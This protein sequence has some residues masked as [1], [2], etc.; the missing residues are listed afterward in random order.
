MKTGAILS[1]AW[2]TFFLSQAVFSQCT[3]TQEDFAASSDRA[4]IRLTPSVQGLSN[5]IHQAMD[6]WNESPCVNRRLNPFPF[7]EFH[8]GPHG[9]PIIT[10]QM[11]DMVGVEKTAQASLFPASQNATI[12]LFTKI[13]V[14]GQVLTIDWSEPGSARDVIAHELGHY[15]GL[16]HSDCFGYIMSSPLIYVQGNQAIIA[17]TREVKEQECQHANATSYTDWEEEEAACQLDPNC[18]P[19]A[20]CG[21][22]C[23]P[24]II[25]FDGGE[26]ALSAG[27]VTFDIDGNGTAEDLT[28]LAEDT[29][30]FI[31]ALD[32]NKNGLIDD[33]KELFGSGTPLND[34]YI[35]PHG[36]AAI[37]E[38]DN[39]AYGGNGD[40][41]LNAADRDFHR[42]LLWN[43]RNMNAVSESWEIHKASSQGLV[44]IDLRFFSSRRT[45][46]H[47]NQLKFFAPAMI[48][49]GQNLVRTWAI[50]VF[51]KKLEFQSTELDSTGLDASSSQR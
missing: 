36:F 31:L 20:P 17:P 3:S 47:G 39:P 9:T 49:R 24:I 16:D 41:F 40:G 21:P 13:E 1:L 10:I 33:G 18:N 51:F 22:F 14:D 32:R 50:D 19:D 2:V 27:P 28:W 35:S 46:V 44:S 25:D 30:D 6:D 42:L 48:L 5:E 23:C 8:S 34:G 26:I 4:R 7:T 15:L 43:D 29:G 11:K 37:E 38:L 45:D 12:N